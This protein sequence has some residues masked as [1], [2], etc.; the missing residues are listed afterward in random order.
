MPDSDKVGFQDP[1]LQEADMGADRYMKLVLTI[2][3]VALCAIALP[4]IDTPEVVAAPEQSGSLRVAKLTE[5]VKLSETS[6][7][8]RTAYP[9]R[10][11]VSFAGHKNLNEDDT[12]DCATVIMVSSAS[13]TSMNV[14]VSFFG[15]TDVLVGGASALL[16]PESVQAFATS[17][18]SGG[19]S[20][21]VGGPFVADNSASTG[22]FNSGF[23]RVYSDDPRIL[24][25]AFLTC[26]R[27]QQNAF[28]QINAVRGF[29]NIPAFPVGAT[30]QFFQA[31]MPAASSSPM[32]M[33][34]LPETPR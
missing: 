22:N 7:V 24:V 12:N 32:A 13:P 11:R 14:Q 19:P 4:Q 18:G 23:A 16:L 29:M 33:P 25:A 9:L 27:D 26:R 31:G 21:P 2:I 10:W 28:E 5:E 34:E 30:A 3:A 17:G 20:G 8:P 1:L 6:I 15:Q